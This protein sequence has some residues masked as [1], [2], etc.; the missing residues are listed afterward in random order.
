MKSIKFTVKGQEREEKKSIKLVE[1]HDLSFSDE[2]Q[3]K[4][5]EELDFRELEEEE[6]FCSDSVIYD[7]LD[8]IPQKEWEDYISILEANG[9]QCY[10]D[11]VEDCFIVSRFGSEDE[12]E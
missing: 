12:I 4:Y 6:V 2:F 9:V 11:S 3:A 10:Y 1:S 5:G 8:N 7:K